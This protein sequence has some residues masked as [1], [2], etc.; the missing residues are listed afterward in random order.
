V[1]EVKLNGRNGTIPDLISPTTWNNLPYEGPVIAPYPMDVMG[2]QTLVM[3]NPIALAIKLNIRNEVFRREIKL[4]PLWG[5][6]CT[7]CGKEFE[8]GIEQL[9]QGKKRREEEPELG[10]GRKGKPA[11]GSDTGEDKRTKMCP[12]CGHRWVPIVGSPQKCPNCS[13]ILTK[14]YEEERWPGDESLFP[15]PQTAICDECGGTVIAPDKSQKRIWNEF[16]RKINLQGMDFNQVLETLEDDLNMYD[17]AYLIFRFEYSLDSQ[18]GEVLDKNLVEI[19]RGD[20]MVMRI[21]V[22][23]KGRRGK[24]AMFATPGMTG[25]YTCIVHRR[26]NVSGEKKPCPI[27]GREMQPCEY[28]ALDKNGQPEIGFIE[29]EVFHWSK[30]NPTECYGFSPILSCWTELV[31]ITNVMRLAHSIYQQYRPPKGYLVFRT[32]NVEALQTQFQLWDEE[33]KKNPVSIPRIAVD[34]EAGEKFVEWIPLTQDWQELQ[35]IPFLKEMRERIEAVFGVSNI[36]MMDTTT[37]GGLNNEGLQVTVTLRTI[38]RAQYLWEYKVFPVILKYLGITDWRVKFPPPI[39]ED[40]MN[41]LLRRRLNLELMRTIFEMGGKIQIVDEE[42]FAFR[43]TSPP[44]AL[45][46]GAPG[47]SPVPNEPE[48]PNAGGK[49]IEEFQQEKPRGEVTGDFGEEISEEETAEKGGG[50]PFLDA[51]INAFDEQLRQLKLP[52][53]PLPND[54]KKEIDAFVKRV[55]QEWWNLTY[56]EYL[57]RLNEGILSITENEYPQDSNAVAALSLRTSPLWDA[58]SGVLADVTEQLNR[59]IAEAFVKPEGFSVDA[60]V[61]EMKEVAGELAKSRLE[62]I[63]RTEMILMVNTGRE[64]AYRQ[65]YEGEGLY[66]FQHTG[67]FRECKECSEIVDWIGEGKK[68]DEIKAKIQELALR[69]NGPSWVTRGW[70]L[71]PNC[72]GV[73]VKVR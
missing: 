64:L 63:A 65:E 2:I 18:T 34:S 51:L 72:R 73:I 46:P 56:E 6:K 26:G 12:R 22:D 9:L 11:T 49:N 19:K 67:D 58:Y 66:I 3:H 50:L 32:R 41:V 57:H 31:T 23:E 10:G 13:Y 29:D 43:L 40:R 42:D 68:L 53:K 61:S 48:N 30:Y 44:K 60:L 59:R 28:V 47:T 4:V 17:D 33:M 45:P 5:A 52:A 36:L 54:I 39:E 21:I 8:E 69:R 35:T 14:A 38:S 16:I 70:A 37:S 27:C 62:T 7:K 15:E 71:H 1:A 20:P 55:R 24:Y 25:Y